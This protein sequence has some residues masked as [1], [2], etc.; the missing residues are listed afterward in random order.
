MYIQEELVPLLDEE[1]FD[2]DRKCPACRGRCYIGK[3]PCDTC[4]GEGYA[5]R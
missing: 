5:P 4:Y 2:L 3:E 1:L